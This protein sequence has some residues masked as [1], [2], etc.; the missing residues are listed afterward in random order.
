MP[1][2]DYR[3]RG[4]RRRLQIRQRADLDFREDMRG[5]LPPLD[6]QRFLP[7]TFRK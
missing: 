5:K 4:Q 7:R 1:A 6:F 3:W 2:P